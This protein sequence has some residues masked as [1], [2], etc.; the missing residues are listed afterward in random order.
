MISVGIMIYYH[1]VHLRLMLDFVVSLDLDMPITKG[2]N[3]HMDEI[4]QISSFDFISESCNEAI[5][6]YIVFPAHIVSSLNLMQSQ[7]GPLSFASSIEAQQLHPALVNAVQ[8]FAEKRS[9]PGLRVHSCG[10]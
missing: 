3:G 2:V 6:T 7:R 5:R 9:T 4:P 10:A 8:P 1:H